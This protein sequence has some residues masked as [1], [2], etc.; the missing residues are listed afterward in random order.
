MATS[1]KA[2]HTKTDADPQSTWGATPEAKEAWDRKHGKAA[3]RAAEEAAGT[4]KD[5]DAK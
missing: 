5:K 4:D 2:D 1:P 3:R